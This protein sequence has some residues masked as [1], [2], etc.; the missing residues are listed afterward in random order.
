MRA[1][2]SSNV[3]KYNARHSKLLPRNTRTHALSPNKACR[4]FAKQ[5]DNDI[6]DVI[7]YIIDIK[8]VF[9]S[10]IHFIC[11]FIL[12]GRSVAVV[13]CLLTGWESSSPHLIHEYSWL[14]VLRAN[15]NVI[16]EY[17]MGKNWDKIL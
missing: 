2:I 3:I 14:F 6:L 4:I 8:E 7:K 5:H 11:I 12:K 17:L 1:Y 9:V 16:V 15:A 10:F 13:L